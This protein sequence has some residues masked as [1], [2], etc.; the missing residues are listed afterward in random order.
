MASNTEG[1]DELNLRASP[2]EFVFDGF[3]KEVCR[4]M[5][6]MM[7]EDRTGKL[8]HSEFKTLWTDIQIWKVGVQS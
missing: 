1:S 8:G 3:G 7:D 4:S 5:V 2:V 6:A